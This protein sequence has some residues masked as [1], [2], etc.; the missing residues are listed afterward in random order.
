MPLHWS[1]TSGTVTSII[2]MVCSIVAIVVNDWN[3]SQIGDAKVTAG[4]WRICTVDVPFVP[5]GC[6]GI[7]DPSAAVFSARTFAVLMVITA[8]VEVIFS[9]LVYTL[10]RN[11]FMMFVAV[12]VPAGPV[13]L[14]VL[15]SLSWAAGAAGTVG[16]SDRMRYG[17]GF[18]VQILSWLFFGLASAQYFWA[19]LKKQQEPAGDRRAG[20]GWTANNN[21][22]RRRRKSKRG[23]KA[24][25]ASASGNLRRR[26][27]A[28]RAVSG[29]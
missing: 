8:V 29:L 21:R 24:A 3:I 19:Y 14:G 10:L 18:G 12:L 16:G 2:G 5:D 23:K 11:A 15:V 22:R 1:A 28:G 25:G 20:A 27:T 7:L 13:A 26:S 6:D 4:L 17:I 9:I